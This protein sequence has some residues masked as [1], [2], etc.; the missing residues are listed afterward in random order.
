MSLF[1]ELPIEEYER[2]ACDGFRISSEFDLGTA[3]ALVWLSQLAYEVRGARTKLDPISERWSLRRIVPLD[4]PATGVPWLPDTRGL[5]ASGRGA[6]IVTFAG[7]DPLLAANWLTN[8][9]LGPSNGLL[10]RGFEA[11]LQAVW[12]QVVTALGERTM[13][14]RAV[15][16]AGHSLGGALAVIAAER[17]GREL[18][19]Q[20]TAVYTFG[21]PRIGGDEFVAAYAA[22]GLA[23]ITYRLVHGH[24][25]V[26]TVP[27][28][29]LRFRHVGRMLKCDHGAR[30]T[31][32]LQLA[33][34]DG[35]DPPFVE[36]AVSGL[37]QRLVQYMQRRFLPAR[38]GGLLGWGIAHL[39]PAV[40]D[41]VPD[42]YLTALDPKR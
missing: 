3:R 21:Q 38:R 27:P 30:F 32:D 7:T 8:F 1:V 16:F 28:P 2:D 39:P 29:R 24:D 10:H 22:A 19:V 42:R 15:F 23:D 13:D 37:R 17:A 40:G 34:S 26:P 12:P 4:S 6:T 41:H 5:V 31:A 9:N 35:N 14:E 18:G 36:V 20:A 25:I 11:A 33:P